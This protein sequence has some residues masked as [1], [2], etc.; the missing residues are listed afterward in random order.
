MHIFTPDPWV[1]ALT[2]QTDFY[3]STITPFY[4][5]R[6]TERT[7]YATALYRKT[8]KK[9]E[10]KAVQQIFTLRKRTLR[11]IL[12]LLHIYLSWKVLLKYIMKKLLISIES[13]A[14]YLCTVF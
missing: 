13:D 4:Q 7:K 3:S 6:E 5:I 9:Y 8:K 2:S 10:R 1:S 14:R 11:S 12:V